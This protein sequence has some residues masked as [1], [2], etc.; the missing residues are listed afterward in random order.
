MSEESE[1]RRTPLYDLHLAAGAKMVEFGGW[2]MPVQYA[3]IIAEHK[4]VRE[5]AGIFDLSHM[6]RV[7]V[8]GGDAERFLQMLATN[9]LSRLAAGQV[10]YSLICNREGGVR[11]DILAYRLG[12]GQY[13]LVVNASN[14]LKILGWMG[15]LLSVL[16]MGRG[17]HTGVPLRRAGGAGQ[18]TIT[19]RTLETAMV[20]VQGPSSM[21]LLQPL[22]D[23]PL[24]GIGYYHGAPARVIGVEGYISRTG[25]TGEDGFEVILPGGASRELWQRLEQAAPGVGGALCGLGARDTLRL[26]AG[27]PL[28][29]HELGEGVNPFEVGLDRYVHPDKPE[30]VG[31]D[32]LLRIAATGPRRRLVGL[33]V[34][35]RA[36]ARQ[37]TPV[38]AGGGEVGRVTSGS[39]SP[40]LDRSIAMALVTP[41]VASERPPLEVSVRGAAH[42][43]SIVNLPFYR[44][45]RK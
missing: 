2:L 41:E 5:A 14:R 21:A 26:E 44:R 40:T 35:D 20:G 12:D 22:T 45:R 39:F 42:P 43:A 32:A 11:D 34:T 3:G 31:R 15:E 33:E 28:Y 1:L 18:V 23:L 17:T 7:Y 29:G 37:G 38:V 24:A 6:G 19:D 10:Q 9:D 27:M 25:Y 30:L 8:G 36:I 4:K 16:Q 13:M